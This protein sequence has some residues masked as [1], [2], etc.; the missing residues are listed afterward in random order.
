MSTLSTKK[1]LERDTYLNVFPNYLKTYENLCLAQAL[2]FPGY[3][4]LFK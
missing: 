2:Q 3:N 1:R 4:H